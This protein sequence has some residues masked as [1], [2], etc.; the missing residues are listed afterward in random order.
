MSTENRNGLLEFN[1][2]N[3]LSFGEDIQ[4]S[5]RETPLSREDTAQDIS[6]TFKYPERLL[7]ALAIMGPNASGKSNVLKA[8]SLMGQFVLTSFN[9]E[10]PLGSIARKSFMGTNRTESSIFE[11]EMIID[12]VW[13]RYGYEINDDIV[14]S[15]SAYWAP[16]GRRILMFKRVGQDVTLGT[17]NRAAWKVGLTLMR[18]NALLLSAGAFQPGNPDART[19]YSWFLN[20]L[21]LADD[22][23]S[24]LRRHYTSVMSKNKKREHLVRELLQAADLG[25]SDLIVKE[26][27]NKPKDVKKSKRRSDEEKSSAEAAK[28]DEIVYIHTLNGEKYEFDESDESKG[29]LAWVSLIGPIVDALIEGGVL[30]VDELGDRLHPALVQQIINLFQRADTNPNFG[31]LIFNTHSLAVL[32]DS[33]GKRLLGRDQIYFTEKDFSGCS[34]I[35][36]LS[37]LAPRNDDAI[38]KRYMEGIYGGVPVLDF[39]R[40]VAA[41][42]TTE[43]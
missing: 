21:L 14:L 23:T 10:N 9:S 3:V 19:L 11:I 32:G 5:F 26:D 1:A 35:F 20:N 29:T 40:Y 12:G 36:R 7:P 30:L 15:E 38:P 6:S 25:L 4:V 8:M 41:L 33:D 22:R 2:R 17:K 18:E 24:Y 37:D 13:H 39:Q 31:Q 34:R 16:N 42:E 28:Q 43:K 27:T